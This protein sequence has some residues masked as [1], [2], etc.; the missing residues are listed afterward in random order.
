M[1]FKISQ[2]VLSVMV[3]GVSQFS[4]AV[5]VTFSFS[6]KIVSVQGQNPHGLLIGDDFNGSYTFESSTRDSCVSDFPDYCNFGAR[7]GRYADANG[8]LTLNLPVSVTLTDLNIHV[9]NDNFGDGF[10]Y[11]LGGARGAGPS[12][13]TAV[14]L[15]YLIDGSGTA[16]S[17]DALP[18]SPP[19]LSLFNLEH[20]LGEF[21]FGEGDNELLYLFRGDLTGFNCIAGC[22]PAE[23]I[24][25]P[26][27]TI[28]ILGFAL[29]LIK[30]VRRKG[31][32]SILF[33]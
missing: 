7:I 15:F 18:L 16:L 25:P 22:A 33:G 6:G 8:T 30:R 26:T 20:P 10:D 17:S 32:V 5:P 23:I 24:E 21:S 9:V 27:I 4:E 13:Q 2:F 31:L 28:A 3:F 14:A 12:N 19:D 29:V 1:Y 11:Y